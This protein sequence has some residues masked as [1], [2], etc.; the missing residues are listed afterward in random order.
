MAAFCLIQVKGRFNE[1]E[2][3][4]P[5]KAMAYAA[6]GEPVTE[7]I[8]Q[9]HEVWATPASKWM[10]ASLDNGPANWIARATMGTTSP[11]DDAAK[12]FA[13]SM[14]LSFSSRVQEMLEDML[15]RKPGQGN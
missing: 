4:Y 13:A 8:K 10:N 1:S 15:G 2:F 12:R 11:R 9:M 6:L 5:G 3:S 7:W 14:Q